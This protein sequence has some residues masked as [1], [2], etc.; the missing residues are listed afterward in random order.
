[1]RHAGRLPRNEAVLL[2]MLD[3]LTA[4][5]KR[6]DYGVDASTRGHLPLCWPYLL[7]GHVDEVG[8]LPLRCELLLNAIVARI[9]GARFPYDDRVDPPPHRST[10]GGRKEVP[11]LSGPYRIEPDAIYDD[12]AIRSTLGLSGGAIDRAR[13]EGRLRHTRAGGRILYLGRWILDWLTADGTTVAKEGVSCL[14][15]AEAAG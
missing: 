2:R 11:N 5:M 4:F 9:D 13:R 14:E 8:D 10:T 3:E 7:K 12:N 15:N 1:M 6:P